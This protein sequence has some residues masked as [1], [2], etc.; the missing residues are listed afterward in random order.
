MK[1]IT[2]SSVSHVSN[3]VVTTRGRYLVTN[4]P[5]CLFFCLLD[6]SEFYFHGPLQESLVLV[7]PCGGPGR[8]PEESPSERSVTLTDTSPPSHAETSSHSCVINSF[9]SSVKCHFFMDFCRPF[10]WRHASRTDHLRRQSTVD[11]VQK[12][13]QLVGER[14]YSSLW[15]YNIDNSVRFYSA[16]L[17]PDCRS[18]ESLPPVETNHFSPPVQPSVG[19]RWSGT[20]ARSSLPIIPMTT[21]PTKCVCGKSQSQR[22]STLASPFSHLR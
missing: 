7:R 1:W 14:L 5:P 3:R 8:V 21:S 22:V 12:Q 17:S 2:A 6:C 9:P 10:L 20:A 13:Q 19:E 15:R 18:I 16:L 11:W 4:F